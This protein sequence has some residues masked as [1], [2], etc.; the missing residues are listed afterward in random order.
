MTF[1][2][3]GFIPI[4]YG[5]KK[6][7]MDTVDDKKLNENAAAVLSVARGSG[8]LSK[9]TIAL[10]VD[11][12]PKA[13][14]LAIARLKKLGMIEEQ[15]TARI[16]KAGRPE[17]IY[18]LTETG[19]AWLRANG[20]EKTVVPLTDDPIALA[21]R[22]CQALVEACNPMGARSD[23]ESLIPLPGGRNI[24]ID[25]AVTLPN[26][27]I[28]LIEIEQ[29]LSRVHLQRAVE[30]FVELGQAFRDEKTGL[31]NRDVLFIFN[32]NT[33]VLPKTI[34]MW[35]D[36]LGMAFP[37]DTPMP[38]T[39]RYTTIDAFMVDPALGN[40]KRF[41]LVEKREKDSADEPVSMGGAILNYENAPSTRNILDKFKLVQIESRRMKS[42]EPDQLIALCETAVTIYRMSFYKDSPALKYSTFPQESVKGLRE[43]LH[44]PENTILLQA[45]KEAY[46]WIESRKSGLIL[47][48]DA[49]TRMVWDVIMRY[50]GL[51]RNGPL[52]I[53][54]DVPDLGEKASQLTI[55]VI[56]EKTDELRLVAETQAGEA[57]SWMLTALIM[58]PVD[59]GLTPVLWPQP[60]TRK[61][62]GII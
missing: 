7:N 28:Q 42:Y 22:Y 31:Y 58:Y 13:G 26:G 40:M 21:H 35:R 36:A 46:G 29:K 51:G 1:K 45:L 54:V 38:F 4:A 57:I 62:K 12:S 48:R 55:D 2:P 16:E 43:Y 9:T 25:V 14:L 44:M 39:P 47:Y 6:D 50:F 33:S 37:G 30:K 41:A 49:V 18:R 5:L 15:P 56:M 52:K 11:V 20:F 19:G 60:K 53:F 8:L 17:K 24:R 61:G 10:S 23:V 59:L 27:R 3:I 34:N 32:L